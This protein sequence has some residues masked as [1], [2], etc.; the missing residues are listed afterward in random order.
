LDA[1][2]NKNFAD[3]VLISFLVYLQMRIKND[4]EVLDALVLVKESIE[5][6]LIKSGK[7]TKGDPA[8]VST[9]T[10]PTKKQPF[11]CSFC[12]KSNYEVKKL[13]AGPGKF[14][15]CNECVAICVGI[16]NE[17]DNSQKPR[18]K[19]ILKAKTKR[20]LKK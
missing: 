13:I 20:R 6:L 19:K 4:P 8:K 12:G 17:P 14:F 2:S 9:P 1:V 11:F 3:A 18:R 5:L 15:L 10:R 16:I 7:A